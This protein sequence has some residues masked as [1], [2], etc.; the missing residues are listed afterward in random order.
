M[1]I[2]M[3]FIRHLLYLPFLPMAFS[4]IYVMLDTIA[5]R[6]CPDWWQ[7]ICSQLLAPAM[8]FGGPSDSGI[9]S[10]SCAV[11]AKEMRYT[12]SASINGAAYTIPAPCPG[13]SVNPFSWLTSRKDAA[14]SL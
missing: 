13:L 3:K 9:P 10:A 4:C 14:K 1:S 5:H 7:S 6:V 12:T 8:Q 2:G 11:P